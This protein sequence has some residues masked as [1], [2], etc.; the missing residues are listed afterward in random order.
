MYAFE[1]IRHARGDVAR[2]RTLSVCHFLWQEEVGQ[3]ASSTG[4]W[5]SLETRVSVFWVVLVNIWDSV[6]LSRG[7]GKPC[8][9]CDE[10]NKC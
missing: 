8:H 4:T 2:E 1:Y 10:H 6:V 7:E 9:E 5:R 3:R